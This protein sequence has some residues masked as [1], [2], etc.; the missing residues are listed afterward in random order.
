[1]YPYHNHIKKR[2]RNGE[3]IGFEIQKS[4][5]NIGECLLLHFCTPPFERPVRP[6]RFGEYE[7]ILAE[8]QKKNRTKKFSLPLDNR[9]DRVYNEKNKEYLSND[10]Q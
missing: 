6:T 1:M 4:Y 7:P 3:L 5:K 2:I 10:V 9:K 8:W